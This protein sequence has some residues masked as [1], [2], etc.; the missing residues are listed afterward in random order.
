MR[1]CVDRPT[2]RG[3]AMTEDEFDALYL[4]S[5]SRLVG[6]LFAMTGD[7]AEAQDVVQE[8]FI[9][10]WD[11]RGHSPPSTTPRRGYAR[12]PGASL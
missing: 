1:I 4:G 11:R 7:L 12:W 10:A 8:G 6:A 3:T 9:R 5:Y 2:E